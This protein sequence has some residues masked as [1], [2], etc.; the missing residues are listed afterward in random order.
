[1]TPQ[2]H[3]DKLYELVESQA[4]S[5]KMLEDQTAEIRHECSTLRES[6]MMKLDGYSD[7]VC[8]TSLKRVNNK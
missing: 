3:I 6:L 7:R 2:E 1:M 5:L 8:M 4:I